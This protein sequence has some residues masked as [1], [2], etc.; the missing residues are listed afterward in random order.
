MQESTSINASTSFPR[1]RPK[2]PEGDKSTFDKNAFPRLE[3]ACLYIGI[4]E[5]RSTSFAKVGIVD[6]NYTVKLYKNSS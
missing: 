3:G 4:I 1:K 5:G 6:A 2:N